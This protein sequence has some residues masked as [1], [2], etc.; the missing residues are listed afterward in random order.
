MKTIPVVALL[1]LHLGLFAQTDGRNILNRDS[2]PPFVKTVTI[3]GYLHDHVNDTP[4]TS[5]HFVIDT[6][7]SWQ[8][9]T[10]VYSDGDVSHDTVVWDPAKRTRTTIKTNGFDPGRFVVTYNKNG[11]VKSLSAEPQQHEAYVTEFGYDDAKRVTKKCVV[12]AENQT[13]ENYLYDEKGRLLN[14]K[15]SSGPLTAKNLVLD[16]EEQYTYRSQSDNYVMYGL[17]YGA[18][19]TVRMRDTVSVTF[20]V[21]HLPEQKVEVM[22]NA[23]WRRVT[24]YA[25]DDKGRVTNVREQW[26]KNDEERFSNTEIEYDSLGY[27]ALYTEEETMYGF[28]NR[29]TT[30]YNERG[31]PAETFYTTEAEIFYYEWKYEYR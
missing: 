22:E 14:M 7:G 21:Q 11:T 31:L 18:G 26:V 17:Y 10:E 28:S 4:M 15:R 1:L 16:Y 25:Y 30:K 19:E 12:F 23:A 2:F 8:T 6:T 5:I 9:R 20:N 24:L 13:V 29:W 27:Y 3:N